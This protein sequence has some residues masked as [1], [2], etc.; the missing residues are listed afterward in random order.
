[1]LTA[2]AGS[3]QS[4][5]A[6]LTGT[7]IGDG[8]LMTRYQTIANRVA[9]AWNLSW[10]ITT[11][12]NMPI[13]SLPVPPAALGGMRWTGNLTINKGSG[14]WRSGWAVLTDS[15]TAISTYALTS[16][17]EITANLASAGITMAAGGWI[18]GSIE[19]EF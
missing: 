15:G 19:Y 4:Y 6:T 11:S 5:T 1:M 12:G 16:T 7:T 3:W 8:S 13:I 14:A 17:S 9:V 10:G 2:L 18:Q